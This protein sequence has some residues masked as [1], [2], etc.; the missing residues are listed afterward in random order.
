MKKLMSLVFISLIY[1]GVLQTN[2]IA[3]SMTQQEAFIERFYQNILGR[4]ADIGGMNTWLEVI[5]SQSAAKVALGF[6]QSQE[7]VN[8]GLSNEQYVDIL[9]QTLFN[10]Q[11]DSGGREIWLNQ[12]ISGVGKLEVLYGFLNAQEFQNLA[13]S[14]GVISIRPED[15][16]NYSPYGTTGVEGYVNRFYTLVLNRTPDQVGFYDWVS[17]LNSGTKAG[18][19]IAKGFFGSQEYLQRGLDNS[20]FLDICYRAFFNREADDGGKNDWLS[21]IDS[22]ATV[23]D[24]L[25]GFIGSQEFYNLMESFGLNNIV[26]PLSVYV[27]DSMNNLGFYE[28]DGTPHSV[29]ISNDN[30]KAFIPN[31][32]KGFLILD[33]TTPNNPTKIVE[34]DTEGFVM[35]MILSPD[36]TKAYVLDTMKGVMVFDVSNPSSPS[37]LGRY[38]EENFNSYAFVVSND[39][40][41][42]YLVGGNYGLAVID[43]SNS[44]NPSLIGKYNV[45]NYA[46]GIKISNNDSKLYITDTSGFNIVDLSTPTP[47]LLSNYAN[48]GGHLFDISSDETK[49]FVKGTNGLW[50]LDISNSNS[51]S[52]FSSYQIDNSYGINNIKLSNDETMLYYTDSGLVYLDISN[53]NLPTYVG[54]YSQMGG[55][56][57]FEISDDKTKAYAI[58]NGDNFAILDIY[59]QSFENEIGSYSLDGQ[60][61]DIIL[62]QDKTKVYISNHFAGYN[63]LDVSN[64]NSISEVFSQDTDGYATKILISNDNSKMYIADSTNGLLIFDITNLS[65][66]TLINKYNT[67]GDVASIKLSK[68]NTKI[69]IA[70]SNY[71]LGESDFLIVNIEDTYNPSIIG[72][73]ATQGRT[74]DLVLSID[75]SKV[76]LAD[77]DNGIISLD[78]TNPASPQ[79]LGSYDTEGNA[80]KIVLSKNGS[81]AYVVDRNSLLVFDVSNLENM[82]LLGEYK[83]T[84]YGVI[85]S[86]SLSFDEKKAYISDTSNGLIVLD[87]ADSSNIKLI[88]TYIPYSGYDH[89]IFDDEQKAFVLNYNKLS[90]LD[91]T[92]DS[93]FKLKDFGV[94]NINLDIDTRD[95]TPL[96]IDVQLDR[97]DIISLGNYSQNINYIGQDITIPISSILGQ[98][99][100]TKITI[101]VSTPEKTK[102]KT[103]YFNVAP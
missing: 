86:V 98:V 12:L 94:Y 14:F 70:N 38:Y 72:S 81:K 95:N 53:L 55:V 5:Q 30:T 18:G 80:T 93:F 102:T 83:A 22:G 41:K 29:V 59:N 17:Q 48:A 1:L 63:I 97:N 74:L 44:T 99:G 23:D 100:Q 46:E 84:G 8:L 60:A 47:T 61:R 66:P 37:L 50:I 34:Y 7:F 71:S 26:A 54:K 88:K 10:R 56:F 49:A 42:L 64:I 57:A 101:N 73:Y 27:K 20:T 90:V 78:I 79:L 77:N 24:I 40:S 33:I 9:Y 11:A 3:S 35:T 65:S 39:D 91:M 45:V 19:D 21:Q 76:I 96:T 92:L 25:N 36:N 13:D 4:S 2:T 31:G 15:Q 85:N 62:S 69:F 32:S 6:F 28:S 75:E 58:V 51:P 68:D 43:V 16:L 52:L 103:V 82:T 67:G 87:I 89:L